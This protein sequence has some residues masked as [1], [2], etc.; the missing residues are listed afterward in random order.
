MIKTVHLE[1]RDCQIKWKNKRPKCYV[2]EVYFKCENTTN[3]KE[4]TWAKIYHVNTN[5]KEARMA[6]LMSD[7]VYFRI[8]T[9]IRNKII[10]Q[11]LKV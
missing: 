4:E 10:S 3:S 1:D 5:Q 11:W 8:K 6:I 7:K 2:K 9:I